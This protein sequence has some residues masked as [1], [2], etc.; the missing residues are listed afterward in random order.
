MV[1]GHMRGVKAQSEWLHS[2]HVAENH[3]LHDEAYIYVMISDLV[4]W[5][6]GCSRIEHSNLLIM[7]GTQP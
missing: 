5:L 4:L 7:D 2:P 1:F 6:P 3:F